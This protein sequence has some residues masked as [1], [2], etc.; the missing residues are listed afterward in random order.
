MEFDELVAGAQSR[1]HRVAYLLCH[2]RNLA[3]DL[4]QET[5]AIAFAKWSRVASADNPQ[6]YLRRVLVNH[7]LSGQRRKRVLEVFDHRR[8]DHQRAEADT[9]ADDRSHLQQ[10]LRGLSPKARTVL[11]L[12]YYV[13]LPDSEIANLLGIREATVRSTAARALAAV[14]AADPQ[15]MIE[16]AKLL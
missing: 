5:F 9:G 14:R 3:E 16:R 2:D 4:V 12:R 15:L 11:V 8:G 7:Y 10:L 6:A 1:L 13:D